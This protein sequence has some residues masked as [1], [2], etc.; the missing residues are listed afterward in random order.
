[1]LPL[2]PF[3]VAP[4]RRRA[5]I[6]T[7]NRAIIIE[8]PTICGAWR[9]YCGGQSMLKSLPLERFYRG[10]CCG[11][12]ILQWLA[13]LYLDYETISEAGEAD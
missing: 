3:F 11:A 6:P 2:R 5:A 12:L 7:R 4:L 8:T 10:S 9:L 13:E 1:M